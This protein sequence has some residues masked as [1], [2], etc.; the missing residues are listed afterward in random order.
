MKKFKKASNRSRNVV[1]HLVDTFG[2]SQHKKAYL[3]IMR[4]ITGLN[5]KIQSLHQRLN[6]QASHIDKIEAENTSIKRDLLLGKVNAPC[7]MGVG[8]GSGNLVVYGTY[9]SIKAA[10]AFVFRA[11]DA[12]RESAQWKE[13]AIKAHEEAEEALTLAQHWRREAESLKEEVSK[14]RERADSNEKSAQYAAATNKNLTKK[15]SDMQYR[16]DSLEH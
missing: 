9:E 2:D 15:L 7:S 6:N 1:K 16:L 11:E 13:T 10:Q 4:S 12:T 5:R 3:L 8:D 14:E